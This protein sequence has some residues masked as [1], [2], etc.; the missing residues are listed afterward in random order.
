LPRRKRKAAGLPDAP[1][2]LAIET[3]LI[4]E[5]LVITPALRAVKKARPES[6]VTVMVRPG[7]APVLIGNPHVDRLLAPSKKERGGVGGV[8]RLSAWIRSQRFDAALVFH[9]SFRSALTAALGAVPV[10]AGLSSE[11]RGFALTH[12]ASRDRSAYEVEEHLKVIGLLGIRPDGRELE[13][14]LSDEERQEAL[15]LIGELGP[16]SKL[17]GLHPGA[18][19]RTRRWPAARFAELAA[20]LSREHEI[21][22]VFF[23]GPGEQDLRVA[24]DDW[25]AGHDLRRPSSFLPRN[26]RMLGALFEKMDAVVTNN[27]GPMH[28]AAAVGVRGV[29]IHGPTPVARWQPPGERYTPLFAEDVECRPCDGPRCRVDRLACMEAVGVDEVL[30]A[31][32]RHLTSAVSL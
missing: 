18:S 16:R 2:L 1:K 13:L 23:Y 5:L 4:G 6:H 10:R 25:W 14:H 24:V 31:V 11:G 22:P 3:G 19:R 28:I 7:S 15:R 20:R 32:R 21:T 29:F 30:G 27:T 26:I 8:L 12:R 9:T 17:V